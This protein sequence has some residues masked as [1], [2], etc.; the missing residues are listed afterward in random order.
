M[1]FRLP[2]QPTAVFGKTAQNIGASFVQHVAD[3]QRR[4]QRKL[5]K[6]LGIRQVK[7]LRRQ[8]RV[9][10]VQVNIQESL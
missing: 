9:T 10:P 8:G 7:K 6:L 3:K 1:I 2:P 4:G 5:V